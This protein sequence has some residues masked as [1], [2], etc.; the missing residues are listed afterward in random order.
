MSPP[1]YIAPIFV[2]MSDD[3]I[4]ETAKNGKYGNNF[5]RH[6]F[7]LRRV[8]T[9]DDE[10]FDALL[11]IPSFLSWIAYEYA[12]PALDIYTLY[13]SKHLLTFTFAKTPLSLERFYAIDD[14]IGDSEDDN[15]KMLS[16]SYRDRP[17]Q[18][19]LSELSRSEKAARNFLATHGLTVSVPGSG[20]RASIDYVNTLR[21]LIRNA[22]AIKYK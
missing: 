10:H 11:Q 8:N 21:N 17:L 19:K 6:L 22:K 16:R 3:R 12:K 2:G 7:K 18:I 5:Y 20:R 1:K 4:I 13:K 15:I 9:M 14:I